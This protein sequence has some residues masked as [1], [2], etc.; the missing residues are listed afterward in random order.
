MSWRQVVSWLLVPLG[1][2]LVV[3]SVI[4]HQWVFAALFVLVMPIRIR[5]AMRARRG[6]ASTGS[7]PG[8]RR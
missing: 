2:A 1:I 7:S 6:S 5:H 3:V 4:T 8:L